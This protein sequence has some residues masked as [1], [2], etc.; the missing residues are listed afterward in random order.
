M[1]QTLI[2]LVAAAALEIAGDAAIRHGLLRSAP[3]WLVLGALTLVT[4]GLVVNTNRLIDFGRLMGLY[5][6]VFF[7]VSQVLSFAFF[8]ERP[9]PSVLLGGALIVAGGVVIQLGPR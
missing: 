6:A 7:V 9:S 4:Y 3:Y 5:I 2:A 8:G 1:M